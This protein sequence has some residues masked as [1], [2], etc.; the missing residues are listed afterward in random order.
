MHNAWIT[1]AGEKMSKSLGNSLVVPAVLQR[2]RAIELRYYM[3]SAHY[4]SH[5]EFSFEALDEA[6]QGFQRIEHFLSRAQEV[7]GEIPLGVACADFENA[8]DDDLSTP[9][10]FAAIF[11]VVREGNKALTSGDE[12]AL[13]GAA[14]S[15]RGMLAVLGLDPHDPEWSRGAGDGDEEQLRSAVDALV[16]HLLSQRQEAR[17]AK[18]FATADAIRDQIK[19]AGIEIEDGPHGSSWSL[20]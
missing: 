12:T 3:V 8:M 4:R 14:G 18:D 17:A 11:E 20:R 2:V 9:A 13:R 1:T 16:G 7:V 19:A 15:V 6:A 5:V 10:A